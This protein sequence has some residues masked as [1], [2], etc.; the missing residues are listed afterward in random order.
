MTTTLMT[1]DHLTIIDGGAGVDQPERRL[2]E[3]GSYRWADKIRRETRALVDATDT[4][5]MQLAENLWIIYDTPIENDPSMGSVCTKWKDKD[6][7]Y[8]SSFDRYVESELGIHHKK[9]ARLRQIWR[10]LKVDLQLSDSQLER[11]VRLG[12]CKVRELCRPDVMSLT[13]VEAWIERAESCTFHDFSVV[14]NQFLSEK[15]LTAVTQQ[16]EEEFDLE[17]AYN[18]SS[19]SAPSPHMTLGPTSGAQ[20]P[21]A[22]AFNDEQRIKDIQVRTKTVVCKLFDDQ[23]ET[24]ELA[25]KRSAALAGSDKIGHNLTLICIDFLM[26]NDAKFD[27]EEQRVRF[28]AK[29]EKVTG[30]KMILVDP[31]ANE[32]VYGINT[33]ERLAGN[34]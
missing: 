34:T 26:T 6:G 12:F 24:V 5:Y 16:A 19:A 17:Q 9:A 30:F 33:L 15:M 32:V 2:Y 27:S 18:G 28:I 8:F 13:N 21:R 14:I 29:L 23:I 22:E 31:V 25:F 11:V 3:K 7:K 10:T 20:K 4:A 1:S